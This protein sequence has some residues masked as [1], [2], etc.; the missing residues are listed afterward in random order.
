MSG[1]VGR[2]Y[3]NRRIKVRSLLAHS[4]PSVLPYIPF[5]VI[6]SVGTEKD[7]FLSLTSKVQV[8]SEGVL[9]K[10]IFIL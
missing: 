4:L 8:D 3:G 1:E 5:G 7:I 2:A 10:V 6:M 9:T